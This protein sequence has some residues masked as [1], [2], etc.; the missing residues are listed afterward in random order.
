MF[1]DINFERGELLYNIPTTLGQSGS[2]IIAKINDQFMI[3]G[4]H[5]G[6]IKNQDK[7]GTLFNPRIIAL[8]K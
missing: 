3:I 4:M 1:K 2:P 7:I 6:R 8:M 5:K